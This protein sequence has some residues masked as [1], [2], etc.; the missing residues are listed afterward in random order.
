M[1]SNKTESQV[2]ISFFRSVFATGAVNSVLMVYSHKF[3]QG[4]DVTIE[5]INLVADV[6]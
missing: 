5:L 3:E 6:I 2:D 1:L 4:C